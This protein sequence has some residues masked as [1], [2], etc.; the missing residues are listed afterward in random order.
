MPNTNPMLLLLSPA[1]TRDSAVL[2]QAARDAEWR[3]RRVRNWQ[4]PEGLGDP[5]IAYYGFLR[6]PLAALLMEALSRV[7]L[8]PTPG[9]LPGLPPRY[10]KLEVRLTTLE[11][12]RCSAKPIFLKPAAGKDF[13]AGIYPSQRIPH[14]AADLPPDLPVLAAEPVTWEH[15]YRRFVCERCVATLAP[16]GRGPRRQIAGE[17][18][19]EP[20]QE[21]RALCGPYSRIP[22]S[23]FPPPWSWTSAASKDAGGQ[24]WKRTRHGLPHSTAACP[25]ASSRCSNAPAFRVLPSRRTT[26][27]G[28]SSTIRQTPHRSADSSA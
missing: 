24:W 12:S 22:W 3:V 21:A 17:N 16:Y 15:E 23:H 8:Q 20:E 1:F 26:E 4:V 19:T 25:P 18:V 28:Y 10:R 9:W 7:L 27:P 13:P 14:F 6:A 2:T 5:E 11:G